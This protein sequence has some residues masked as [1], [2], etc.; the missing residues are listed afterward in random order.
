MPIDA[1]TATM[2]FDFLKQFSEQRAR[3]RKTGA[4]DA[5]GLLNRRPN[6]GTYNRVGD[7]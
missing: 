7:V 5:D 3:C 1:A 2:L 4:Y 6:T